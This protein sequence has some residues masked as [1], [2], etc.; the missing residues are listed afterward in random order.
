MLDN[1]AACGKWAS[2]KQFI[3]LLQ[4]LGMA[5]RLVLTV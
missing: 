3:A 5:Y 1:K 4:G 2:S